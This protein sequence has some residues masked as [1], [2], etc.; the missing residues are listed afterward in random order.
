MSFSKD[1]EREF[2]EMR[3]RVQAREKARK[4]RKERKRIRDSEHKLAEAA[5]NSRAHNKRSGVYA[6]TWDKE[7]AKAFAL[8]LLDRRKYVH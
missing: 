5:G 7:A 4:E 3:E 6:V 2:R 8:E 1:K